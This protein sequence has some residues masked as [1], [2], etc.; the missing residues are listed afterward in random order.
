M[1][2]IVS[3]KRAAVRLEGGLGDHLLG[4]RV[5]HFVHARR[6]DHEI[7]VYSDCAG[8]GAQLAIAAMSP[9]V[10]S[11]VPIYQSEPPRRTADMGRLENLRREDLKAMLSADVFIEAH[12]LTMF[13]PAAAELNVPVF[14]ILGHRPELIVPPNAIAEADRLLAP[15][16]HAHEH[17][18][19]NAIFVGLNVMK[20]GGIVLRYYESRIK[21]ILCKLLENPR[22]V[23]LN[24]FTSQ[25]AFA[26][27]PQPD[28]ELREHNVR[29]ESAFSRS[30]CAISH[31]VVP[32]I[33]LPIETTA[34]VLQRCRYF[35]GVDN[36]TKHLA[37]ALNVPTTYFMPTQV[38]TLRALRWLPDLHRLL[39]FDCDDD[40]LNVHLEEARDL[41][42]R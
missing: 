16:E 29:E 3:K 26:H 39:T 35:V 13:I 23:V 8:A 28:R 1:T 41:L 2:D 25:Y 27:W 30:L 37:W 6:P 17:K 19:D 40:E 5:L 7:V 24:L 33:D 14:D 22:V 32:L 21:Q 31:R 36:G 42:D 15:Y 12:G 10:S 9:Y 18:H 34:A 11:V 4:M 38:D 20:Y